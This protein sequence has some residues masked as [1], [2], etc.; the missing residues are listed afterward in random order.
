[1]ST[2]WEGVSEKCRFCKTKVAEIKV[3]RGKIKIQE[4]TQNW[5]TLVKV[6]GKSEM[7]AVCRNCQK[8]RR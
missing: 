6:P 1:M 4:R 3:E 7:Y 5:G 2:W 8:S